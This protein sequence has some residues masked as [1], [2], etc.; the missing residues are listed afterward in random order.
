MKEK[1]NDRLNLRLTMQEKRDVSVLAAMNDLN[2]TSYLKSLLYNQMIQQEINPD[3]IDEYRKQLE[4]IKVKSM[5]HQKIMTAYFFLNKIERLRDL[6]AK[7][8]VYGV[9]F[10]TELIKKFV[11]LSLIEYNLL[12]SSDRELLKDQEAH[13]KKFLD[14]SEMHKLLEFK[15]ADKVRLVRGT[16]IC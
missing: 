14:V 13:F 6:Y 2:V 9:A 1:K 16:S 11:N 8:I 15:I 10:P 12:S 4:K 5:M 7:S 3:F